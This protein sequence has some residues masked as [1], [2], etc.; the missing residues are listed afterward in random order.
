M[1]GSSFLR[2][3]G[4]RVWEEKDGVGVGEQVQVLWVEEEEWE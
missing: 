3:V 2:V 4:V 1:N